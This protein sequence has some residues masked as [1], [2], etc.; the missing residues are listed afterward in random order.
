M[1]LRQIAHAEIDRS[2]ERGE[3]VTYYI[4]SNDV[5]RNKLCEIL[6]EEADQVDGLTFRGRDCDGNK[7]AVKVL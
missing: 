3:T 5:D 4:H 2:L 7:W 1:N 6:T